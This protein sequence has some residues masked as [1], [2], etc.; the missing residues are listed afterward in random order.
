MSQPETQ[1]PPPPKPTSGLAALLAKDLEGVPD[2]PP[3][4]SSAGSA[5]ADRRAEPDLM[6]LRNTPAADTPDDFEDF[7]KR[8]PSLNGIG[9]EETDVGNSGSGT[10]REI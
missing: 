5:T 3:Q 7:S 8:Y 2:Y 6:G 9:M 1:Q 4:S 10:M